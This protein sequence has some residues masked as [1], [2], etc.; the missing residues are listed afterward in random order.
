M[1]CKHHIKKQHR[2]IQIDLYQDM[3]ATWFA[4]IPNRVS[5]V[6]R[7]PNCKHSSEAVKLGRE[8]IDK[9][10]DALSTKRSSKAH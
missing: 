2:G 10:Y 7:T 1:K 9:H 8:Y 4:L 5:P 3:D 6:H